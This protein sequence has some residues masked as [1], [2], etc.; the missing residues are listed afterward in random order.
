MSYM[1]KDGTVTSPKTTGWLRSEWRPILAPPRW[2]R[3]T[4]APR[5]M[6]RLPGVFL[7]ALAARREMLSPPGDNPTTFLI[8]HASPDVI[9]KAL[10]AS[11]SP[12]VVS[13]Q[14]PCSAESTSS[15]GCWR[16]RAAAAPD[17]VNS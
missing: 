13:A 14:A 16:A 4:S 3:L 2:S 9:G 7:G 10:R 1:K 12:K 5:L 6:L 15:T 8:F 17:G 11:R